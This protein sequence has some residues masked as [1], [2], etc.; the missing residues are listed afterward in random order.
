[1]LM[2][3]CVCVCRVFVCVCVVCFVT[4][5]MCVYV[6][7]CVLLFVCAYVCTSPQ[8]DSQDGQLVGIMRVKDVL[9]LQLSY[10]RQHS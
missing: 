10:E 3:V 6:C 4:F 8:F 2:R 7:L 5:A 9:S 1:V